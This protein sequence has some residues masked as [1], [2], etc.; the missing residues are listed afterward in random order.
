VLHGI[1]PISPRIVINESHKVVVTSNKY[2]F[3]RS[4]NVGVNIIQ[5]LL[6]A[7]SRCA[8]FHLGLLADDAMFTEIQF[9]GS[10]TFQ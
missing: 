2:S 1:Y 4:P 10:S 3:G 6:G 5:N 9:A 8:E 7:V